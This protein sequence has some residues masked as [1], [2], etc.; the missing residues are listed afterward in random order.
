M[1]YPLSVLAKWWRRL[2]FRLHA[3]MQR[4]DEPNEVARL[5]EALIPQL[6][7]YSKEVG[8]RLEVVA[9]YADVALDHRCAEFRGGLRTRGAI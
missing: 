7:Q 2:D 4:R 6:D 3:L 1:L 5:Y 9:R 8:R